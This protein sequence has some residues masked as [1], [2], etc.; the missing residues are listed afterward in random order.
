[1]PFKLP[2][3]THLELSMATH[4]NTSAAD[5]QLTPQQESFATGLALGLSQAEAYRRAY[6]KSVTWKDS[7]IWPQASK[8][9]ATYKVCTRVDELKSAAAKANGLTVELALR[10]A[11]RLAFF[12]IR[13]LLD[14]NGRPIPLHELDDDT[15]A[16][17]QG[18]ELAVE[19]SGK[20]EETVLTEVRRY[21]MVDKNAALE[22]VFKHL[23]LYANEHESASPL[24]AMA[25]LLKLV[26]G[27]KLP[28]STARQ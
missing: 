6:P 1:M 17:I 18:L 28:I 21:K 11:A 10:E 12:D 25:D 3:H 20:G 19:K 27:S 26:Q 7:T 2:A 16:A 24:K 14:A 8:L 4:S 15:A 13:K 22:R 9:A 23:N 5:T